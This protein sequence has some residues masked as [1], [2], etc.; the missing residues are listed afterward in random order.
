MQKEFC[1]SPSESLEVRTYDNGFQ[2]Q[3]KALSVQQLLHSLTKVMICLLTS[4]NTEKRIAQNIY[5]HNWN[6]NYKKLITTTA[7]TVIIKKRI[8]IGYKNYKKQWCPGLEFRLILKLISWA[9]LKPKNSQNSCR[10]IWTNKLP[11]LKKNLATKFFFINSLPW[12]PLLV[13]SC[14]LFSLCGGLQRSGKY[15]QISGNLLLQLKSKINIALSLK[16]ESKYY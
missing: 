10:L 9:G 1:Y 2:S 8:G 4:C 6:R 16:E 15:F 3:S 7:T 13:Y 12:K 5:I 14:A 11:Q